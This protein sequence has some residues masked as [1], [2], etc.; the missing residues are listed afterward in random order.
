MKDAIMVAERGPEVAYH[1]GSNP[2]EAARIASLP[3]LQQAIQLGRIEA[4][5]DPPK[6]VS[7]APTPPP[8]VS[9]G[10]ASSNFDPEKCTQAEYVKWREKSPRKEFG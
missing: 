5:L 2:D 8:T 1:L 9:K 3:P 6:K 10:N 7:T 4:T